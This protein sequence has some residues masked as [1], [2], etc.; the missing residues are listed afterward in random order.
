MKNYSLIIACFFLFGCGERSLEDRKDTIK[1]SD[2]NWS[3]PKVCKNPADPD[4]INLIINKMTLEQKVGQ[5]IMPDLDEVTPAEAK[6]YFLG[7][8]LNGGGKFPN[9]DKNSSIGDWKNLSE[10]FYNSSPVVNGILVPILWGTDAVHGH[11]NVIGATIFPHNIGLGSTMNPELIKEIGG[12]VAKELLSTGIA[13]TFAPTITVPQND[14]WGR[15]YEGYSENPELVGLLGQAMIEGLQGEG[16]SFLDNN[17]VLSTA[18]HFIGD[19]GTID[20]ED[21]GNTVISESELRDTH[22]LPYY[23][24]IDSCIQTI[25]ASFNSW[26]GDK[27]HGNKYLLTDILKGQMQ[28]DGLIVGDW[29]GHGQLPGCTNSN[30]AASF[31]AGVDIFMAP[32]EWKNLYKNTIEQVRNGTITQDR[33]DDAIRRILRVKNMLGLFDNKKPHEYNYNSIGSEEHRLVARRA[34]RESLVLLKNNDAILPLNPNKHYLVVGQAAVDIKNQMGGW[35]ISWQGRDNLNSEFPN[36]KSI[37]GTI[38]SVV[39]SSNGS[40][41]FSSDG[42]YKTK[43]DVVIMVYGEEPYAEGDGDRD[44][45]IFNNPNKNFY[46]TMKKVSSDGLPIVSLFL[47]GRPMVVNRELNISK[48]FVQLWL[49]GT[50][51]EGITDLIFT[52]SDGSTNY[53]FKGKLAYSWP[54]KSSQTLLNLNDKDYQ[55]LFEYGYGLTYKDNKNLPV[56]EEENP[57]TELDEVILFIGSAYPPNNEFVIEFGEKSIVNADFF[58]SKNESILL[59]KMDYQKQ[60]DAKNISFLKSSDLYNSWG[61]ENQY[62][63]NF[64]YM[65]NAILE[66]EYRLNELDGGNNN[67]LLVS[68]CKKNDYQSHVT[69]SDK[70]EVTFDI[71]S[72]LLENEIAE[73]SSFK[74]PFKC[75]IQNG[76]EA[77]S[78]TSMA[79]FKSNAKLDIDIH[80]IKLLN[81]AKN[82][83]T[84]NCN[85]YELLN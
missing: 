36:T 35:T 34:V 69:G 1:K 17:H 81:N 14:L 8:F 73:W 76:L 70:C 2:V 78:I 19:G 41:E 58:K 20:G 53:D 11:N 59:K 84:E 82:A 4:F 80:S 83:N 57:N 32:D 52:K 22:G 60:D 68:K 9:K 79:S 30:C 15:T 74:I 85:L 43:P 12:V 65:E 39:Q 16:D 44:S 13:W 48:A 3:N 27:M 61:I 28:F 71:T 37:F 25:M 29:N 21:Q 18:K 47:S 72:N 5:I 26:N 23:F 7:S 66:I 64:S 77:S 45:I 56:F 31:N 42:S 33:L 54:K 40:V 63:D 50:A 67:L 46:S 62:F 75:F 55:P 6:D 51:V 24:A 38:K 10:E 49:P